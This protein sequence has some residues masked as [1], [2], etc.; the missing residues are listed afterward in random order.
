MPCDRDDDNTEDQSTPSFQVPDDLSIP[1]IMIENVDEEEN[2]EDQSIPSFQV[3][4]EL[5]D[6]LLS[7]L[8]NKNFDHSIQ[9]N[10]SILSSDLEVE[11][12]LPE[13]IF[14]VT[15]REVQTGSRKGKIE[16]KIVLRIGIHTSKR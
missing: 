2:T 5:N 15:E 16:K 14:E 9:S 13:V 7:L 8:S 1:S 10:Q 3:P 6:S 4:D 12:D 11:E